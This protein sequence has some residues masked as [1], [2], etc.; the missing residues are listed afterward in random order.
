MVNQKI[1]GINVHLWKISASAIF[2][3]MNSN[4]APYRS[5]SLNFSYTDNLYNRMSTNISGNI[6]KVINFDTGINNFN[7]SLSGYVNYQLLNWILLNF[8]GNYRYNNFASNIYLQY[9]YLKFDLKINYY[10]TLITLGY[11]FY[12]TGYPGTS[13]NYRGLNLKLERA[14]GY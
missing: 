5:Y 3:Q 11:N 6:M 8:E 12:Y 9:L 10:N 14:F 2:D 13:S 7:S 1:I 4:I